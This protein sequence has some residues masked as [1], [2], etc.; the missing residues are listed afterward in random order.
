MFVKIEILP[1]SLRFFTFLDP[2]IQIEHSSDYHSSGFY[3][4]RLQHHGSHNSKPYFSA[5][6][7]FDDKV[8][9]ALVELRWEPT[10]KYRHD[11]PAIPAWVIIGHNLDDLS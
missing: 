2:I 10:L 8:K 1:Y 9:N 4:Q 7:K 5:H 6:F 3:N 11:N